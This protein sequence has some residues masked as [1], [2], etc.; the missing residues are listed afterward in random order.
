MN[1]TLSNLWLKLA[2]IYFL[3]GVALGVG[4]GMTGDHHLYPLHAHINLLGWVSM[5]LF[6]L[7][8]RVLEPGKLL[9][10]HFWLYNLS[11]PVM[12]AALLMVL[13]GNPN[14]HPLLGIASLGTAA[15]ILA[16]VLALFRPAVQTLH[17]RDHGAVPQG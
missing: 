13:N 10:L 3:A 1:N 5:A 8:T 12:C 4:M 14:L 15:G 17:S 11:L 9:T 6:G 2:A 16:F 7:I